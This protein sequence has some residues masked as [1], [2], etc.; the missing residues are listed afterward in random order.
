MAETPGDRVYQVRRA[1]GPDSRHEMS[2]RAFADLLNATAKKARL[3]LN[4]TDSTI[5][6]LETGERRL[7]LEEAEL[8]AMIDPLERGKI[9]LAFGPIADDEPAKRRKTGR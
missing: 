7:Q 5:T 4:F 3:D 1:L 9:W 8:I 6:R 2:Q